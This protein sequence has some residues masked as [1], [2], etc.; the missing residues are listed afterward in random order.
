MKRNDYV[1]DAELEECMLTSAML[2]DRYG[3]EMLPILERLEREYATR[4]EK[5]DAP[6]HVD[7]IKALL[8]SDKAPSPA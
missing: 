4:K 8:A 1:S 5:R 2:V 3:D 6:K 7:R